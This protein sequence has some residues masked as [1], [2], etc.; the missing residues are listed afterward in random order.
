MLDKASYVKSTNAL[1]YERGTSVASCNS[2]NA[3]LNQQ[4]TPTVSSD[5][6]HLEPLH[7]QWQGKSS[8]GASIIALTLIG[9]EGVTK[10]NCSKPENRQQ[11]LQ[12]SIK[13]QNLPVLSGVRL[14]FV[15]SVLWRMQANL[16][17]DYFVLFDVVYFNKLTIYN[18]QNS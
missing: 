10:K 5:E 3:A 7:W 4:M 15:T 14:I 16:L 6:Q 2:V 17:N 1:W 8:L 18:W 9:N 13:G 12:N 11:S